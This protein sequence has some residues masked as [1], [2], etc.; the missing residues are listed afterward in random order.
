MLASQWGA[1]VYPYS[2]I[3]H[4]TI[5]IGHQ[6]WDREPSSPVLG[7]RSRA[8]EEGASA[9]TIMRPIILPGMAVPWVRP[10]PARVVAANGLTP[11]ANVPADGLLPRLNVDNSSSNAGLP[12]GQCFAIPSPVHEHLGCEPCVE[13]IADV[14]SVVLIRTDLLVGV[15]RALASLAAGFAHEAVLQARKDSQLKPS[16]ISSFLRVLACTTSAE[17]SDKHQRARLFIVRAPAGA[18][19][20]TF[21]DPDHHGC[22]ADSNE[23]HAADSSFHKL[24]FGLVHEIK[25][26]VFGFVRP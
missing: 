25:A 15:R 3:G 13:P 6:Y 21:A 12:H 11:T 23:Q 24:T 10:T 7:R 19:R 1:R 9:S 16:V 2:S 20:L 8:G 5:S 14:R 26:P 18:C 22:D 4:G 17:S